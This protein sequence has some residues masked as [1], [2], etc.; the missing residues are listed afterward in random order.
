MRQAADILEP[1]PSYC[2][3]VLTPLR[4]WRECWTYWLMWPRP[5]TLCQNFLKGFQWAAVVCS[6]VRFVCVICV[7]WVRDM[8]KWHQAVPL[9]HVWMELFNTTVSNLCCFGAL[10]S[11]WMLRFCWCLLVTPTPSLHCLF[12]WF[13]NVGGCSCCQVGYLQMWA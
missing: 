6:S 2:S 13:W 1:D 5:S 10:R 4:W 12:R 7:I 11:V 9:I 3:R 8:F